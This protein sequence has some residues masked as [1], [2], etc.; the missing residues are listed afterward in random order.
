MGPTRPSDAPQPAQTLRRPFKL[1]RKSPSTCRR[2][3]PASEVKKVASGSSAGHVLEP[4]RH[5]WEAVSSA[6]S[7]MSVALATFR[8][9]SVHSVYCVCQSSFSASD[10]FALKV[11]M[12]SCRALMRMP[13]VHLYMCR[14]DALSLRPVRTG[15]SSEAGWC[16]KSRCCDSTR[17]LCVCL[18]FYS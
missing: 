6:G 13:A 1:H 14:V 8:T 16:C 7:T 3:S 2:V 10:V 18:H 4:C 9:L 11:S 5:V 17:M 15:R 12:M